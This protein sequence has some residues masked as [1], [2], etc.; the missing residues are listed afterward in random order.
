MTWESWS[1]WAPVTPEQVSPCLL[2]RMT[3]YTGEIY[4]CQSALQHLLAKQRVPCPNESEYAG[5]RP[6]TQW[7]G[8]SGEINV[9]AF[10]HT[11]WFVRGRQNSEQRSAQHRQL[12]PGLRLFVS[13]GTWGYSHW[14]SSAPAQLPCHREGRNPA[15]RSTWVLPPTHPWWTPAACTARRG[16][17]GPRPGEWWVKNL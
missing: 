1:P 12:S 6:Q 9:T 13:G 16:E 7:C 8:S 14:S 5:G 3:S 4:I 11:H 2:L 10:P 17:P 15:R